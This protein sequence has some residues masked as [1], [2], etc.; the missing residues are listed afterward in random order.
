MCQHLL[1]VFIFQQ[2]DRQHYHLDH[3]ISNAIHPWMVTHHLLPQKSKQKTNQLHIPHNVNH[4]QQ[5]RL[6]THQYPLKTHQSLI[7]YSPNSNHSQLQETVALLQQTAYG[8]DRRGIDT[9]G[10]QTSLVRDRMAQFEP[11]QG[12]QSTACSRMSNSVCSF[13]TLRSTE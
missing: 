8:D 13:H 12:S 6:P 10:N 9:T 2:E 11:S 7:H 4:H 1:T 5:N 3:I